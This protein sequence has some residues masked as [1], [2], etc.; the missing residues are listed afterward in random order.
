MIKRVT[1]KTLIA[2]FAV[3][4]TSLSVNAASLGP[5]V[6]SGE[7]LGFFN[8]PETEQLVSIIAGVDVFE[9]ERLDP[10]DTMSGLFSIFNTILNDDGDLIGGQWAYDGPETITH[11]TLTA[12]SVF[13]VYAFDDGLNMGSFSSMVLG[14]KA[15]DS[16][17]I[18]TTPV[19]V[20][21]AVW[22][23][24]SGLIGLFGMRRKA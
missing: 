3:F 9:V 8:G 12:G 7:Y 24:M 1:N 20:P 13:A 22:L 23:M 14:D 17:G 19:P 21:A 15:I 16:I 4:M 10:P 18:Y 11:I 5:A 2:I 6:S